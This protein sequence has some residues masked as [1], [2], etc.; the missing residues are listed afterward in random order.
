MQSEKLPGDAAGGPGTSLWKS[1][2]PSPA[3]V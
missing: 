3:G 1:P 2:P